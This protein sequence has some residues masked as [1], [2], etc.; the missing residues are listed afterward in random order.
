[1]DDLAAALLVPATQVVEMLECLLN[2][3]DSIL[4]IKYSELSDSDA[5]SD[6]GPPD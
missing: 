5:D 2:D 1:M 4:A 3:S 6:F